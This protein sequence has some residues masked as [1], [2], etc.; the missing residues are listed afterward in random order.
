[1]QQCWC[2]PATLL[3]VVPVG[4]GV[5]SKPEEVPTK[6]H[7]LN[8]VLCTICTT[9]NQRSP[10]LL[11]YCGQS[12]TRRIRPHSTFTNSDLVSSLKPTNQLRKLHSVVW[13]ILKKVLKEIDFPSPFFFFLSH[14]TAQFFWESM[15]SFSCFFWQSQNPEQNLHERK[16]NKLELFVRNLPLVLFLL[17]Y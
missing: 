16:T 9:E 15:S 14:Q 2:L 10:H 5:Y 12:L 17:A 13:C 11:F 4:T 8:P 3:T 7:I 6:L 1:M